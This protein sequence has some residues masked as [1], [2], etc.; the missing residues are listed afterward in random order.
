MTSKLY[1]SA[2][3]LVTAAAMLSGAFC[4]AASAQT[5]TTTAYGESDELTVYGIG[6]LSQE[7]GT[8]FYEK[9]YDGTP[10]VPEIEVSPSDGVTLLYGITAGVYELDKC[11]EYTHAGEYTVYAQASRG[12]EAVSFAMN[13]KIT[14]AENEWVEDPW[15]NSRYLDWPFERPHGEAK[16][17]EVKFTYGTSPEGPFSEERPIEVG[18]YYMLASV[19]ET[20]DYEGISAVEEFNVIKHIYLEYP[21]WYLREYTGQPQTIEPLYFGDDCTGKGYLRP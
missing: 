10:L 8:F 9:I 7:N 3:A 2:A 14:K 17:G 13:I 18:K 1:R 5:V 4:M 12:G 20:D 19:D 6:A 11:P 16:F 21:G 15:I